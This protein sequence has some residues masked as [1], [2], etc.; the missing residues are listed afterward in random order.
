MRQSIGE[1]GHAECLESR[2]AFSA[3]WIVIP[4]GVGEFV[5]AQTVPLQ[6]VGGLTGAAARA[7][8]AAGFN[9]WLVRVDEPTG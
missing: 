6:A 1:S 9:C 8:E 3:T 2:L 4:P 7:N 5:V